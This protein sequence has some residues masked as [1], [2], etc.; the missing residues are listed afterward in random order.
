MNHRTSRTVEINVQ[1]V[2]RVQR[3]RNSSRRLNRLPSDDPPDRAGQPPAP[4]PLSHHRQLAR[5][6]RRCCLANRR[7]PMCQHVTVNTLNAAVTQLSSK[8][9][10]R[11]SR[12]WICAP[13]NLSAKKKRELLFFPLMKLTT[14]Q[15]L[16]IFRAIIQVNIIQWD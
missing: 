8:R 12:G 13:A 16:D 5:W 9:C 2:H 1:N 3:A 6:W 15:L 4:E 10:R 7:P 14:N 11:D